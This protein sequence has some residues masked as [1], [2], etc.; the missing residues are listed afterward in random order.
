MGDYRRGIELHHQTL[1]IAR[2]IEYRQLEG[3]ELGNLGTCHFSLGDYRKAVDLHGQTVAVAR[4]IGYRQLEGEEIG[5]LG[6]CHFSLGEYERARELL[7]DALAIAREVGDRYDEANELN[8]LARNYLASGNP[9]R[10][11]ELFGQAMDLTVSTGDIEPAAE[12]R[13]G[14][15]RAQLQL[16]N[17]VA[18]LT[19]A[20]PEHEPPYPT[21]EPAARL[22][23]G[24]A[25]LEL[26]HVDES[27]RAFGD[28][29][30][31]A[32]AL[33]GLADSNV[34]ALQARALALSGLAVA[35]RDTTRAMAAVAA[36]TRARAVTRAAGV[37]A[38]TRRLL[39]IIASHDKSGLLITA[40]CV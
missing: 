25:L 9:H 30:T 24:L 7:T 13:S 38:D 19:A 35:T 28:A 40:R 14:W 33:L 6:L 29:V 26:D 3:I 4:E 16:G 31:A 8:Y 5:Y 1:E 27:A 12:A 32:D 18:A 15:A 10:A 37:A 36:F 17:P 23:A 21:E 2:V 11:A 39:E 22:L 34:A 20:A